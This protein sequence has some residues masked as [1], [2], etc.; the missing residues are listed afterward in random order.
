[1]I[2]PRGSNA[3]RGG[4]ESPTVDSG[5]VTPPQDAA[6]LPPARNRGDSGSRRRGRGSQAPPRGERR[7]SSLAGARSGEYRR[8]RPGRQDR[9]KRN[10]ESHDPRV[11]SAALKLAFSRCRALHGGAGGRGAVCRSDT[12][13]GDAVHPAGVRWRAER[14]RGG[15]P[16]RRRPAFFGSRR[17]SRR[18]FRAAKVA[19]PR[20]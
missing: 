14:G 17:G 5:R 3:G 20:K 18:L 12:A 1:M 13:V 19:A 9:G 10:A 8:R 11:R 15:T 2:L 4:A 16:Q 6:A 7:H